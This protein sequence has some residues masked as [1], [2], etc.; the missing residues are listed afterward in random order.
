[1]TQKRRPI[2]G[3]SH[4][5]LARLRAGSRDVATRDPDGSRLCRMTAKIIS[6]PPRA[7][8]VVRVEREG[9]AW[10]VICHDHGWL[11]GDFPQEKNDAEEIAEGFG[12]AVEVKS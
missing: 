12:F 2:G 4:F 11:H 9:P 10:I 6:F 1:M 8:L 7:P 5:H 3:A